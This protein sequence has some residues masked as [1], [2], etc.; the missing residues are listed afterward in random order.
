MLK[1]TAKMNKIANA[2]G[3]TLTINAK[4]ALSSSDRSS[5]PGM[6]NNRNNI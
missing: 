6:P 5:I 4:K 3:T 2:I 1:N